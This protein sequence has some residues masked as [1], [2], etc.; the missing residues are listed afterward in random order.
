METESEDTVLLTTF[1][2]AMQA[3]IA[4]GQLEEE[5]YHASLSDEEIVDTNPLLG[6]AVG[7]VKLWVP[8]S[9][10]PGARQVLEDATDDSDPLEL[11]DDELLELDDEDKLPETIL[12][13]PKCGS[14]DISFAPSFSVFWAIVV[15]SVAVPIALPVSKAIGFAVTGGLVLVGVLLMGLRKFPL[16][17][18]DC[19]ER[20]ARAHFE[21]NPRAELALED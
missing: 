7:G 2:D 20:G 5:G 14:Q 19:A 18:K 10:A 12:T 11:E 6:S 4:K 13:C 16:Q 15:L 17:C 9:E 1:S 3:N 21:D 8:E